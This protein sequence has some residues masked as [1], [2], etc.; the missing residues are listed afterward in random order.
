MRIE[1][2]LRD[3]RCRNSHHRNKNPLLALSFR[4][5]EL[6][7]KDLKPNDYWSLQSISRN[8][9]I[10]KLFILSFLIILQRHSSPFSVALCILASF[11]FFMVC[12]VSSTVKLFRSSS[13]F[14]LISTTSSWLICKS[15]SIRLYYWDATPLSSFLML[16]S[17]SALPSSSASGI[18]CDSLTNWV[19]MLLSLMSS[20]SSSGSSTLK[21]VV[22]ICTWLPSRLMMKGN[23]S[24]IN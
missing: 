8:P 9:S 17:S 5:A 3:K 2:T 14:F 7:Y 19:Y 15:I 23:T 4:T 20:L 1:T 22:K 24:E 6:F 12:M 16:K 21:L 18:S 13:I 11:P 10:M